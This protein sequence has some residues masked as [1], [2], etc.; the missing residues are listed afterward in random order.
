MVAEQSDGEE[1]PDSPESRRLTKSKEFWR[2]MK[3]FMDKMFQQERRGNVSPD[4]SKRNS[5]EEKHFRRME[6]FGGD[7]SKFR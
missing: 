6:K 2:Q 3:T 7:T 4:K 1:N 5:L